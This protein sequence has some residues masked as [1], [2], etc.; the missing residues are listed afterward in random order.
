MELPQTQNAYN[1]VSFKEA[2]ELMDSGKPYVLIDTRTD[3]EFGIEHAEGATVLPVDDIDK[4]SAK[5]VIPD[6]DTAIL[7]YCRTGQR[8][9]LAAEKL[10]ELGYKHIYDIG[11]LVGW[12]YGKSF[13]VM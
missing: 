8:S 6:T 5:A 7:V 12:P 9:K 1:R 11:S 10:I 13:G 2:K 3:E 4:D